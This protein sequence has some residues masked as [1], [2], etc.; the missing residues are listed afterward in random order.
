LDAAVGDVAAD[1][2]VDEVVGV[3]G[4]AAV[5]QR[6]VGFGIFEVVLGTRDDGVG[7]WVKRGVAGI[8]P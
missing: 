4:P 3:G 8:E 2:N 1:S 7:P 6:D 5:E